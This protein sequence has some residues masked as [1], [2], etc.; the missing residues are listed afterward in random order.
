M[1]HIAVNELAYAHPGGEL[2][3]TGVSFRVA[4]GRHAGIVGANGVGK[5]T[6]LRILAGELEPDAG[7]VALGGRAFNRGR[8]AAPAGGGGRDLLVSPAPAKLR[9]AGQT[10]LESERALAAGDT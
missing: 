8:A 9:A 3:F 5:T 10:M 7:D 2:L 6:L 1:A 4:S